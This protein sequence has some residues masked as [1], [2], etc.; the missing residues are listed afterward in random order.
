MTILNNKV[1]KMLK[2]SLEL[3]PSPSLS[4]KIQIMD[5]KVC[6]RCKSKTLLKYGF[7]KKYLDRYE[8][9]TS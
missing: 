9:L 6:F 8:P 3:I 7:C 5:G 1:E 2:G 4:V